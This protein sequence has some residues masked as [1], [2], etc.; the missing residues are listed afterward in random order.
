VRGAGLMLGVELKIAP[1]AGLVERA[2]A[3]GV[4]INLTAR[5]VVRLAPAINISRA[6]WDKGLDRVV[7]TLAAEELS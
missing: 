1:K 4:A 2:L 5:Q 6:D 7:E 3:K